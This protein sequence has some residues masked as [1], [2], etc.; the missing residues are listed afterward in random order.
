MKYRRMSGRGSLAAVLAV[1]FVGQLSSA[2][3]ATAP[4]S[5][6][7]T[8]TPRANETNAASPSGPKSGGEIDQ[9]HEA[10]VGDESAASRNAARSRMRECGHQWSTMKRNGQANGMTWKDFSMSCLAKK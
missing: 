3:G 8:S 1:I 2:F 4:T 9:P 6:A 5:A 7:A 10:A